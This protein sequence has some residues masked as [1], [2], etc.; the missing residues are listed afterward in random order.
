MLAR[1]VEE[2]RAVARDEKVPE[3]S[4]RLAIALLSFAPPESSHRDLVE[5]LEP[6]H[7]VEIQVAALKALAEAGD[8]KFA[9]RLEP[10]GEGQVWGGNASTQGDAR[11]KPGRGEPGGRELSASP[12]AAGEA[13]FISAP[14]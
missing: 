11:G 12:A 2:A 7:P 5:L 8:P 9:P 10:N 3:A 1:L 13:L 4:R 14:L 6:R